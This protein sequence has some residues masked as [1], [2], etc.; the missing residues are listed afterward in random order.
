L[1]NR[2]KKELKFADLHLHSI[3]SDGTYTPGQLIKAACSKGLSAIALVDHDTVNGVLETLE[4]GAQVGIEVLPGIELTAEYLGNE[5]HILGY[6]LDYESVLLKNKLDSL[7]SYRIER[8]YK[9][10]DKLQ[11]IG[12]NLSPESVFD[13]SKNGIPGRLHIARAMVKEKLVGSVQDAFKK[14]IGDKS[15]GYVSGFR[16]SPLEG[17]E[18]IRA[19]RG[20]PVLAH[21]YLLNNDD[22]IP[23]FAE[24]GLMGLEVYYPEHTQAMIN[25]Y[26]DLAKK[27]NL[28]VT[29][30]SDCH[31]AAKPEVKIGSL[32]VSYELVEKL[33]NTKQVLK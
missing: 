7:R 19:A 23:Q 29:G 18:L 2:D 17:I 1:D 11:S 25:Y 5:I 4:L 24:Y 26:L 27:L 28:L 32:K 13:I 6:L 15:P 22:L 21:P 30:G 3:F 10:T 20:I 9:I 31:G 8:V 12:M 33:K 14:Y 16:L